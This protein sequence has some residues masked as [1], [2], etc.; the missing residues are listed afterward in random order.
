MHRVAILAHCEKFVVG[1]GPES[2]SWNR[3]IISSVG[4]SHNLANYGQFTKP[5]EGVKKRKR[6]KI[7]TLVKS[8]ACKLE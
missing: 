3:T 5:V 8:F 6:A 7:I 1:D 2:N 4:D